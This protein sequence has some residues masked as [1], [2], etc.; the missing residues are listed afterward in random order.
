M[1]PLPGWVAVS[2]WGGGTDTLRSI[3]DYYFRSHLYVSEIASFCP[4]L[5]SFVEFLQFFLWIVEG[6]FFEKIPLSVVYVVEIFSCLF[7][8]MSQL[9]IFFAR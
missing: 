9:I 4:F 7:C 3:F 6:L 5:K 8:M 2:H 1:W